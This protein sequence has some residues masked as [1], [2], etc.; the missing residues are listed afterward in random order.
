MWSIIFTWCKKKVP[1]LLPLLNHNCLLL[2]CSLADIYAAYTDSNEGKKKTN[3]QRARTL[4]VL[5][6]TPNHVKFSSCLDF[7]NVAPG[8]SISVT[9]KLV[10]N[11]SSWTHPRL[12][13]SESEFLIQSSGDLCAHWSLGSTIPFNSPSD[14]FYRG[15]WILQMASD[16]LSTQDS[17]LGR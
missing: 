7:Q 4:K 5:F 11:A 1:F 16:A 13:E 6:W 12:C 3:K 9:L 10:R 14:E 2:E 17:E 8:G 15:V